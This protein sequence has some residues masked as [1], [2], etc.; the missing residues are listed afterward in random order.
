MGQS[1]THHHLLIIIITA[2]VVHVKLRGWLGGISSTWSGGGDDVSVV[3]HFS[4]CLGKG[5]S[6][7]S[8]AETEEEGLTDSM[9]GRSRNSVSRGPQILSASIYFFFSP[10]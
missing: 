2:E 8:E 10:F 3:D 6:R 1:S 4:L 7:L 5:S 9:R